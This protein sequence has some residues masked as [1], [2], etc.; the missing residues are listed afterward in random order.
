LLPYCRERGL[1]VAVSDEPTIRIHAHAGDHLRGNL[2]TL[3]SGALYIIRQHEHQLRKCPEHF[4]DWCSVA[5]VYAA[6][7]R[8]ID[9][10]RRLLRLACRANPRRLKN[11]LR[12]GIAWLPPVARCVWRAPAMKQDS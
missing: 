11:L 4:A 5:A 7:L 2:E 10:T 1:E 6:K 9:E 3:L 8:R 12:L